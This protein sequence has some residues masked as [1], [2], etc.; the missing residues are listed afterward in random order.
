MKMSHE[1]VWRLGSQ[2]SRGASPA[3]VR[4]ERT[5]RRSSRPWGS[6]ARGVLVAL[7]VLR[8]AHA[9]RAPHAPDGPG[10]GPVG[11]QRGDSY[12]SGEAGRWA[13]NRTRARRTSSARLHAYY[14]NA[15]HAERSRC[16]HPPS[17]ESTSGGVNGITWPCSGAKAA[18][19]LDSAAEASGKARRWRCTV[20]AGWR[21]H[22]R[23]LRAEQAT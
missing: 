11:R 10:S 19:G 5:C 17:A 6:R 2:T 3:P 21:R 13:G 7:A 18:I 4:E 12:I 22:R 23:G 20:L 8:L 16:C 14:D 9:D 1:P 15:Q